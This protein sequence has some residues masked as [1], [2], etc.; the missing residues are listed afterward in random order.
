SY[1]GFQQTQLIMP[2]AGIR[3]ATQYTFT[4]RKDVGFRHDCLGRSQSNT[5]ILG[6]LSNEIAVL[7][8]QAPIAFEFCN[9]LSGNFYATADTLLKATHGTIVHDNINSNRSASS[10]EPIMRFVGYRY[11]LQSINYPAQVQ[12][13][14]G[15]S[16]NMTWQNVGY[17]PNYP[18]MGQNFQL[19]FY[20]VNGGG[21]VVVD[22]P[23][24]TDIHGWMPANPITAAPPNNN[25]SGTV[26]IP[27]SVAPGTYTTQVAIMDLRTGLPINLAFTGE[28]ST[29]RS[30]IGTITVGDSGGTG[31]PV[32]SN[33]D[34][35]YVP[36]AVT[37]NPT[38]I[39]VTE[40]GAASAYSVVL[41]GRPLADV[42]INIAGNSQVTP[43][44]NQL[45]FT[46]ANWNISQQV[47]VSAVNDTV[48]EGSHNGQITHT[49]SSTGD[50]NYN[51]LAAASVTVNI[52]DN[53]EPVNTDPVIA[54]NQSSV[55]V[56]EGSPAQN[57]GTVS[58][59][60][61]D[62][63]T[64]TASVGTVTK[65]GNN[66][67]WSFNP[68]DG[69]AESQTV[70]ISVDDGNEGSDDVDFSLTVANV[71]PT[72]TF[73]FTSSEINVNQP[74]TLS[75]SN[76]ADAGSDDELAGFIYDFDCDNDG[77]FDVSGDDTGS[78]TC[79][80]DAAGTATAVGRIEDQDGDFTEYTAEITVIDTP[81]T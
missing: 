64:L 48:V 45:T 80:Y 73:A 15:F 6:Q 52:T 20:L 63:L 26:S 67:N 7:W 76:Q 9:P 37:V 4:R 11:F 72:A 28:A 53:D 41:A 8:P 12:P 27:G 2:Y 39:N 42:R 47:F 70:T 34:A 59:A 38:A 79:T 46:S 14:G 36:F 22:T 49:V 23:I 44:S 71:A 68:S 65:N 74:A 56:N 77:T 62:T 1:A 33:M 50:T 16:V 18:K 60:D 21:Q 57:S 81:H 10:L 25:V 24:S 35:G 43:A 55:T 13:G 30:N 69:P 17:A 29:G 66:W 78:T 40:G 32:A 5:Q 75:F 54:A 19:H 51:G 58:D 3:Q 61:G 31:S